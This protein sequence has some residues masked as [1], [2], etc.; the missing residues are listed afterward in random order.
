MT[1]GRSEFGAL[2]VSTV[3]RACDEEPREANHHEMAQSR[4]H[5]IA[6]RHAGRDALGVLGDHEQ[7]R[8]AP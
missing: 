2:S 5:G 4:R 6:G 8:E 7:I 3:T 1:F